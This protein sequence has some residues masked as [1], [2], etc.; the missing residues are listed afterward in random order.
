MM[1][2]LGR[3]KPDRLPVTIHQW[4]PYHL[5]TFMKGMSDIE[6]FRATGLDAAITRS[7]MIYSESSNW[8]TIREERGD[9]YNTIDFTITTPGGVLTYQ[10]ASDKYT[11]WITKH[12]IKNDEDIYGY[13]DYYPD[14]GLDKK[15]LKD[16]YAELNDGGIQRIFLNGYQGGCWQDACELY[17]TE[18]LIYAVFDK[19]DWVHEFLGIL[20]EKK[21]RFIYDHLKGAKIDLVETGGGASSSTVISPSIHRE[22]CLPYDKALHDAIHEVGFPVVYHTCGGMMALLD[23]IPQNGCDVSETLSP[24]GVGGDITDPTSVKNTLGRE[25]ALIGGM[26]Q[27][28]ILGGVPEEA[29]RSEV[30]RLFQG[31]GEGGGYILSACDHFWEVDPGSLKVFAEAG[32]ECKY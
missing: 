2:A 12:L 28:N 1:V 8:K 23:I 22:F 14:V 13:R 11:T 3:E 10:K 32:R 21:T 26:D 15:A 4:Q 31:F 6:A 17:G 20:L 5:N 19:P 27:I 18:Q 30:F 16:S 7:P 9:E 25:V 29:I 24:P